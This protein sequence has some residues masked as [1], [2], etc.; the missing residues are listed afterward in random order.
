MAAERSLFVRER[1]DGLYRAVVYL[2][3]KMV[4][5][6]TLNAVVGFASSAILF[7]GVSMQVRGLGWARMRRPSTH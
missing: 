2:L 7:Y 4:D 3:F 1:S 5:E 6:L